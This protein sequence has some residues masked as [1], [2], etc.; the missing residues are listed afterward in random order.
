MLCVWLFWF[1]WNGL[2]C[3]VSVSVCV[4]LCGWFFWFGVG[5][6]FVW[7]LDSVVIWGYWIDCVSCVCGWWWC[8]VWWCVVCSV[9]CWWVVW[10]FVWWSVVLMYCVVVCW[11]YWLWVSVGYVV[12][13][14]ICF[15]WLVVVLWIWLDWLFCVLGWCSVVV[16]YYW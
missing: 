11:V 3:I 16:L 9:G 1:C 2:L 13:C 15:S 12:V 6:V 10:D 4:G 8:C 7:V 14:C 5:L